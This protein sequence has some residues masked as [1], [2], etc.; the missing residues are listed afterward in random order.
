MYGH[1][2]DVD[3]GQNIIFEVKTS[4]H[5]AGIN[6]PCVVIHL[7][8]VFTHKLVNEKVEIWASL[9]WLLLVKLKF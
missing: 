4:D 3:L 6:L 7:T 5:A 1:V 9:V 2:L 8:L